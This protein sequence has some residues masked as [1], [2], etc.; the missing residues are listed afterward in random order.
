MA[1]NVVIPLLIPLEE[2]LHNTTRLL[3][4]A[5]GAG[6]LQFSEPRYCLL[7][8]EDAP[9]ALRIAQ[10]TASHKDGVGVRYSI[11]AGNRDGLFTID[12][13]TGLI[14]LAAPLDYE[15]HAKHELVVAAE[16][17]GHTAHAIVHVTIADVNDNE[18]HFLE[19]D[20][21]VTVVE[22]EDAHLPT[23]IAKVVAEDPDTVDQEGLVYSVGGEGVDAHSP[24]DAYFTI[25]P[26]TGDLLLLRALDRD[27]PLGRDV[28]KVKVQVRDGQRVSPSLAAAS[29]ASRRPRVAQG[30]YDP[31]KDSGS[32]RTPRIA[33]SQN[34]HS[35]NP[36]T[37]EELAL[38]SKERETP[39][40]GPSLMS[41]TPSGPIQRRYFQ[42]QD[43]EVAGPSQYFL[44]QDPSGWKDRFSL[45]QDHLMPPGQ[46]LPEGEGDEEKQ[47]KGELKVDTKRS[48]SEGEEQR[49][50]WSVDYRLAHRVNER[51]G[52]RKWRNSKR[53]GVSKNISAPK[54]SREK[55]DLIQKKR[56]SERKRKLRD[57][58]HRNAKREMCLDIKCKVRGGGKT[59]DVGTKRLELPNIS[60]RTSYGSQTR[61]RK[62][63]PKL[64]TPPARQDGGEILELS[65]VVFGDQRTGKTTSEG[66]SGRP[67][68]PTKLR[69]LTHRK[70][71]I[72]L[73][74]KLLSVRRISKMEP[75]SQV[76]T[77]KTGI[78]RNE[79]SADLTPELKEFVEEAWPSTLM[80]GKEK[81]FPSLSEVP[82]YEEGLEK[83]E[84][85]DNQQLSASG[86][87]DSTSSRN[88][89]DSPSG[90][91][92]S[93]VSEDAETNGVSGSGPVSTSASGSVLMKD[94][95]TTETLGNGLDFP[96]E[97]NGS[98]TDEQENT[99]D[100]PL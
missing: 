57:K 97:P 44:W 20:L 51:D 10:V 84:D 47:M 27:P 67:R 91:L 85:R 76:A 21:Q 98:A 60:S 74:R 63:H 41:Q 13:H 79:S 81:Y 30:Q 54:L 49:D 8:A 39:P 77:G 12:Q 99:P 66:A 5:G 78:V 37:S 38:I 6:P 100:S 40:K 31:S 42:S 24:S 68:R 94:T 65:R 93:V 73:Q 61:S 17:E 1:V 22:E 56:T 75:T 29:R 71:Q 19:K 34:G 62:A 52:I 28:W 64:T 15:L 82:V 33:S 92:P 72:N 48:S 83:L 89:H 86:P 43:P 14:T 69:F 50:A 58:N 45:P 16:A 18:P 95:V 32:S 87:I 26:H 4:G 46:T 80:K 36:E 70:H 90:S 11:R 55:D 2:N 96:S 53:S 23:T 88:R 25:N 9:P 3:S 7:L 35:Q 59:S